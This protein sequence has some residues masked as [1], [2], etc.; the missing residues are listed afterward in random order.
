MRDSEGVQETERAPLARAATRLRA[1]VSAI[2]DDLLQQLLEGVL[3]PDPDGHSGIYQAG[4]E[5]RDSVEANLYA[6]CSRLEH[7][8]AGVGAPPAALQLARRLVE[9]RV[10]ELTIARIYHDGQS[11]IWERWLLPAL[12]EECADARALGACAQMGHHELTEYLDLVSDALLNQVR[13]ERVRLGGPARPVD[14]VKGVLGGHDPGPFVLG[15]PLD[16]Q[17]LAFICWSPADGPSAEH[18]LDAVATAIPALVNARS[19]LLVTATNREVFGWV[20]VLPTS[21]PFDPSTLTMPRAEVGARVHIAVGT[22]HRGLA[23]FRAS[24]EEA[25]QVQ[26]YVS[27]AGRMPPTFATYAQVAYES[28]L[29]CDRS[30]ARRFAARQLGP[31]SADTNDM[32]ELRRTT[33][34]FLRC[35]RSYTRAAEMLTMHRNTI[36]YRTRKAEQ[37]LGRRLDEVAFELHAAL[38]ITECLD[39]N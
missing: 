28:L 23:G 39:A 38:V 10:D 33:L 27:A 11:L 13:I 4:R 6:I 21:I 34:A 7:G 22:P 17:H 26:E 9:Q 36:N 32:R 35:G 18:E 1:Q 30:A 8:I 20:S 16:G 5:E 14:M 31:M 24:H 29:V 15:H 3:R 2:A 19:H 37:L 25:R 12:I